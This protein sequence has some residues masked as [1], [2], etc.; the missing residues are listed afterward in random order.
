MRL[1]ARGERR[2]LLGVPMT[3]KEAFNVAGLP[4]TWGIPGTQHIKVSADAVAIERLKN[5]GA[6]I[7]GKTNVPTHLADWQT[8]NRTR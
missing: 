7:L 6:I 4:T 8:Y 2:P 1:L 3:V 5:A